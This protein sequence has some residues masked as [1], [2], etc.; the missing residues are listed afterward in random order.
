M[1][2][3]MIAN[4]QNSLP[5]LFL[6]MKTQRKNNLAINYD[7]EADVLY[8][9]FDAIQKADDTE[10]YSDNILLRKKNRRLIGITILHASSLLEK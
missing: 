8:I 5:N 10:I 3:K 7:K 4:L 6:L 9:S 2:E 1:E